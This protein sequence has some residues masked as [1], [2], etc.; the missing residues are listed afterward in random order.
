[1]NSKSDKR[2]T[3]LT[4]LRS[5]SKGNVSFEQRMLNT[6]IQ[7]TS[8]DMQ[9]LRQALSEKDWNTIYQIAHKMK[10]SLHFVGIQV[11]Q[12]DVHTLEIIA[13]QNQ[14]PDK[15]TELISRISTLME[16]AIEEIKDELVPFDEK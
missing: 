1:M 8:S 6:F 14:D 15:I 12:S 13:K 11:L 7:Q 3:D 5:V 2:Y 16:M 10:P 4:Y 9:K